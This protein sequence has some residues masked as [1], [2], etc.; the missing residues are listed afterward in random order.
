MQSSITEHL[1]FP[2]ESE[3]YP[4][5]TDADL[6]RYQS[7]KPAELKGLKIQIRGLENRIDDLHE[8]IQSQKSLEALTLDCV[9]AQYEKEEESQDKLSKLLASAL[10]NLPSLDRKSVV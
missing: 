10:L 7:N 6:E 9:F 1:Q 2:L 8:I 4:L 3:L 5:L